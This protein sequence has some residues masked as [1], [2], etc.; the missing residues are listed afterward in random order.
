MN[1]LFHKLQECIRRIPFIYHIV[2]KV[3]VK[4]LQSRFPGSA[5]YWIRRYDKNGDSGPGSYSRLSEYKA[6]FLNE[7]V[8]Q[9][10]I[11]SVIEYGCGDGN[12]L[13][14]AE[15]QNYLGFDISEKAI[16]TCKSK[17]SRDKK[18]RFKLMDEYSGESAELTLSLDVV[19]HLIEDSVFESYM[20]R[21]LD[22]STRFVIVYSS[23]TDVQ[24]NIQ[25]P[26]V[27]HRNFTRYIENS[28]PEWTLVTHFPNRFEYKGDPTQGSFADF[29]VFER[30]TDEIS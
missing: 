2:G 15:Y 27:R 30:R 4:A 14:I 3:Y 29:F 16:E 5:Q 6:I 1:N 28:R 11:H 23:N 26:H 20:K 25:A 18:K 8:K 19:Y 24:E 17:F 12:Q 21:L 9:N 22:S 13:A 7:F 10:R